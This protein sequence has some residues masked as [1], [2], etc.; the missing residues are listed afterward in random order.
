MTSDSSNYWSRQYKGSSV[1]KTENGDTFAFHEIMG[2][3]GRSSNRTA[4]HAA[5]KTGQPNTTT[6]TTTLDHFFF[7]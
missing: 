6:T 4:L 7:W 5:F 3:R 2:S 1:T